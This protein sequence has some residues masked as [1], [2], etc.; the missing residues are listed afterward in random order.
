MLSTRGTKIDQQIV[1]SYLN[2]LVDT[3]ISYDDDTALWI[4][5]STAKTEPSGLQ[6]WEDLLEIFN[7][8]I[9]CLKN[10]RELLLYITKFEVMKEGLSQIKDVLVD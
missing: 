4:R 5:L 3:S 9:D 10:D 8:L 2:F 6:K 7:D 1:S